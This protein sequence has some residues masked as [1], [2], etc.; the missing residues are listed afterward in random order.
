[1]LLLLNSGV[2]CFILYVLNWL[3]AGLVIQFN[4]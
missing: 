1:L 4:R 2:S 3:I